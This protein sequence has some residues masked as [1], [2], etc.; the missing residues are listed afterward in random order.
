VRC[1]SL[2]WIAC[3]GIWLQ[4]RPT[5]AQVTTG[6][7]PAARP[8]A[9]Q[10]HRILDSVRTAVNLPALAGAI[11]TPDSVLLFDAVGVRRAGGT[12]PVTP[13]DLFSIGS[14]SKSMT[15]GWIALQVDAGRIKWTTTIAEVFPAF[16]N[17]LR[18]EYRNVTL[19]ELLSHQSGFPDDA[20]TGTCS[21]L[22]PVPAGCGFED[23]PPRAARR[24]VVAWAIRQPAVAKRGT[25]SYSSVGYVIA[26][27]MVEERLDEDFESS[28]VTRL[29]APL[30][31]TTVGFGAAA[32][33]GTED[34]PWGH[35]PLR[36]GGFRA[37][38]PG[39]FA[40]LP[41]IYDV[42]GTAHMSVH[43]WGLW[44]RTVL[45]A[46]AGLP[47]PWRPET[48]RRLTSPAVKIDSIS[49]YALGW[50]VTP[51]TWHG[52]FIRGLGHAGSNGMNYAVISV[53]PELGL[54]VIL[55]ANEGG[56]AA[57][58]AVTRT[59]VRLADLFL[60]GR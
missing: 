21:P 50:S 51:G 56:L 43:D 4:G 17:D 8:T 11:V 33:P 59:T 3:L 25:Y 12:A 1:A 19:L 18:P 41:A 52:R 46:E 54:G 9:Q 39:P 36:G 45:R 16:A 13:G 48:A 53:N 27:A 49:G 32:T 40:D 10:L 15:A 31:M 24:R 57:K 47:S 20:S 30:G 55:V 23:G 22:R 6:A 38:P 14:D 34:Q 2:G 42:S 37:I 26:A 29:F 58:E 60:T 35:L 5:S 44:V 7:V 28:I